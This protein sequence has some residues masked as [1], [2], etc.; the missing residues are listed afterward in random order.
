MTSKSILMI[1]ASALIFSGALVTTA[2]A[3]DTDATPVRYD[4][5]AEQT[6]EL[7]NESLAQAQAQNNGDAAQPDDEDGPAVVPTDDGDP[8]DDEGDDNAPV[9]GTDG[10]SKN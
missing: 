4:S 3:D 10:M 1:G 7:N 8:M 2:L 6:R 9:S 5:Q